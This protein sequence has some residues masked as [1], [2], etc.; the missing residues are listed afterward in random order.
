MGTTRSLNQLTLI[1]LVADYDE[2]GDTAAEHVE[3]DAEGVDGLPALAAL[4][5]DDVL[6]VGGLLV[7][8]EEGED[9]EGAEDDGD[10]HD[11]HERG[12]EHSA[13]VV[14]GLAEVEQAGT[15]RGVDDEEDGE[16][17]GDA[18]VAGL[19]LGGRQAGGGGVVVVAERGVGFVEEGGRLGG[20]VHVDAGH[21][22]GLREGFE[23]VSLGLK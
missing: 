9:E 5:V 1:K 3:D 6:E 13:G 23:S 20:G 17:P 4:S 8:G 15:Q 7:V 18:A 10:E 11:L 12:D 21:S 22:A 14:V 2:E 19:D 16:V